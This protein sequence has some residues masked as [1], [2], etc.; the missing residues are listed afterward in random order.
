MTTIHG[1]PLPTNLRIHNMLKRASTNVQTKRKALAAAKKELKAHKDMMAASRFTPEG[2]KK[3]MQK[4]KALEKK[5]EVA[6]TELQKA[7]KLSRTIA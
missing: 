2:L 3:A 1:R 4:L 7:I 5:V 6:T